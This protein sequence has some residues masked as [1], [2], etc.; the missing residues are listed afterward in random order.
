[1]DSRGQ[2]DTIRFIQKIFNYYLNKNSDILDLGCGDG[3]YHQYFPSHNFTGIDV[4]NYP[5][6]IQHNLEQF[7]YPLNNKKFDCVLALEL[8]QFV[9][10]PEIILQYIHKNHLKEGGL[11]IATVPN[12]NHLDEKLNNI[13]ISTYNPKLYEATQGRWNSNNIRFFDFE[14]LIQL[15]EYCGYEVPN[16]GGCNWF[17]SF[18]FAELLS[19]T[20]RDGYDPLS[21]CEYLRKSFTEYAPN[22]LV[23]AKKPGKQ[24]PKPVKNDYSK[25]EKFIYF[26]GYERSAHSL[27]AEIINAHEN[28][29]ISQELSVSL[30][31]YNSREEL[32]DNIINDTI[33]GATERKGH[34]AN[35]DYY[36]PNQHQG[37][38]TE[39]KV[40]GDK[41]HPNVTNHMIS[42]NASIEELERFVDLPVYIIHVIRNPEDNIKSL[43]KM[44]FGKLTNLDEATDYY[45][46]KFNYIVNIL[47][48]KY[49][50]IHISLDKLCKNPRDQITKIFEYL[51]LPVR[52]DY[53]EDCSE[54]VFDKPKQ[55][56]YKE[57]FN[58]ESIKKI[59]ELKKKISNISI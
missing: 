31:K 10:H 34:W 41:Q 48:K 17:N 20:G 18:R 43:F 21:L 16:V 38:C 56:E 52:K 22:L 59:K 4:Q 32:F 3:K 8:F 36:L 50:I 24:K 7:P 23:L 47:G 5:F 11:F 28:C 6:M 14:S 57:D 58:Q 27:I 40:I 51:G 33:I 46:N 30:K 13:N 1:M 25:L 44:K 55:S 49:P 35:Y 53:L 29:S 39:L 37:K 26:A 42:G 45:C 19:D 12:I 54:L 9:H 15:F 2:D